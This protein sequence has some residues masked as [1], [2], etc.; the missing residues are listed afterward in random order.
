MIVL[1]L[2]PGSCT[3]YCLVDMEWEYLDGHKSND[4]WKW[5]S[6]NI[7]EYGFIN[8]DLSSNY[9]GDHCIDLM[10]KIESIIVNN[11]VEHITIEDFFFSKKFANGSNVNGAFRTAIH[12]LARNLGIDYTILNISAWKT[13]VAGRS[14]PTKE[15]KIIWGPTPAKKI[16][17]QDALWKYFSIRF[18]NHSISEKT[19][20]PIVFKYDIVD[21]VAQ[22]IYYCGL[23]CAV[24]IEKIICSVSIP[25]DVVLKSATK[26]VY[27]YDTPPENFIYLY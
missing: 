4:E 11:S 9:Q 12:I 7:Y 16:Y 3:G 27:T 13:F 18:P 19:G 8:V 1:S 14:T 17:M 6:A 24:P 21:V 10:K 23:C 15:Q 22:S 26:K 25:Q 20:K 2:D 5:S